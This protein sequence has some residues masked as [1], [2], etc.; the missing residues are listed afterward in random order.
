VSGEIFEATDPTLAGPFIGV[1]ELAEKLADSE[2]V[3][4]CVATQWFRFA[5]GRSEAAADAC[6]LGTLQDGFAASGG[7]LTELVVAMTQT[8]AFW[9]RSL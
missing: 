5:S 6:S 2:Q 8:D 1:R 3:R 7:D 4:A 9:Y